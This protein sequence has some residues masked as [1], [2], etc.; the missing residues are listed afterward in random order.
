[1]IIVVSWVSMKWT[2]ITIEDILTKGS[3]TYKTV[4]MGSVV[5][6][7]HTNGTCCVMAECIK[8]LGSVKSNETYC[9][10]LARSGSYF[11]AHYSWPTKL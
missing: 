11:R 8:A 3:F 1:M 5:C 6:D 4:V 7:V 2:L 9:T 10:Y